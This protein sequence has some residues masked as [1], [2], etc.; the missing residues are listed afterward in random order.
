[1]PVWTLYPAAVPLL[2]SHTAWPPIT[3]NCGLVAVCSFIKWP[4]HSPALGLCC[5]AWLPSFLRDRVG[6]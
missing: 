3:V 2:V 4:F 1:M 6:L 5:L